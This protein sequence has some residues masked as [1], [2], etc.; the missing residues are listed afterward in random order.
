MNLNHIFERNEIKKKK[1]KVTKMLSFL[2]KIILFIIIWFILTCCVIKFKI[3]YSENNIEQQYS[4]VCVKEYIAQINGQDSKIC[5]HQDGTKTA[6]IHYAYCKPLSFINNC[7][8]DRE[9]FSVELK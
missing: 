4:F 2:L 7:R 8:W 5:E 1:S 6:M 3:F 9:N